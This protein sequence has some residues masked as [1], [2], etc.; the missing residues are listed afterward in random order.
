MGSQRRRYPS[1]IDDQILAL[2]AQGLPRAEIASQLGIPITKVHK[3]LS[4]RG[5]KLTPEQRS[6]IAA[7]ARAKTTPTYAPDIHERV[8]ALRRQG[9]SL[10]SIADEL[11]VTVGKVYVEA[12]A[13]SDY[14]LAP[15]QR[16]DAH[17][18]P[19]KEAA[20]PTRTVI[21]SPLKYVEYSGRCPTCDSVIDSRSLDKHCSGYLPSG[22]QEALERYQALIAKY[23]ELFDATGKIRL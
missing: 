19:P 15:E 20:P 14:R 3:L 8:D 9:R 6:V 18:K 22:W 17:R 13:R 12:I 4:S 10:R 7:A 21:I 16:A 11:G 1:D 2:Q 5:A 23:P